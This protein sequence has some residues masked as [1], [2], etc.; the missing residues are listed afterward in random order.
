MSHHVVHESF[1]PNKIQ[2]FKVNKYLLYY[3]KFVPDIYNLKALIFNSAAVK[4]NCHSLCDKSIKF[5]I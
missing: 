2:V 5:G 1:K 4:P 3:T